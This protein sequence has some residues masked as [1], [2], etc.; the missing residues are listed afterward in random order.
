[1]E[2]GSDWS[3]RGMND[4]R[5]PSIDPESDEH[6]VVYGFSTPDDRRDRRS[7]Y[8]VST[9]DY[10]MSGSLS[11]S[12]LT[13][14]RS[15]HCALELLD[16]ASNGFPLGAKGRS[17]SQGSLSKVMEQY[18]MH[19][20]A[21]RNGGDCA[22]RPA[23]SSKLAVASSAD[24]HSD[25]VRREELDVDQNMQPSNSHTEPVIIPPRVHRARHPPGLPN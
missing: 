22:G 5:S 11:T 17:T 23:E 19:E 9:D 21:M 8:S 24:M 10:D 18:R 25:A 15:S 6:P 16:D 1:M 12:G 4:A 14:A 2:V 20:R 3:N 13:S 7:W